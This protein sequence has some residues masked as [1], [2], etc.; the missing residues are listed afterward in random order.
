[1]IIIIS[2]DIQMWWPQKL[3]RLNQR[4]YH[5]THTSLNQLNVQWNFFLELL[6]DL[7]FIDLT[8]SL[9]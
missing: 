8:L 9:K 1:M 7:V 2:V 5:D 3:H 4:Q 6:N